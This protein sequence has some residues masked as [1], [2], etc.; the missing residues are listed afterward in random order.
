MPVFLGIK[1]NP[2]SPLG[3]VHKGISHILKS[4]K[5]KIRA[6]EAVLEKTE[7]ILFV[8]MSGRGQLL[9]PEKKKKNEDDEFSATKV[10]TH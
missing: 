2:N 6:D 1:P 5:W 8:L 10:K 9:H 7:H 4:F 3:G